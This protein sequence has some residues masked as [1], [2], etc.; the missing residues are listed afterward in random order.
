[1]NHYHVM[2]KVRGGEN[3]SQQIGHAVA[4]RDVARR[5]A[6][7]YRDNRGRYYTITINACGMRG[8]YNNPACYV[9]EVV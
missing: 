1:M 6:S 3:P 4:S 5:T 2:Q 7:E 8:S 9:S